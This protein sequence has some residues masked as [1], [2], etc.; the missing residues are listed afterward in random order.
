MEQVL[1]KAITT[2]TETGLYHTALLEWNGFDPADQTWPELKTH[3]TE[4]YD[5]LQ[6]SG[7]DTSATHGYHQGNWV[8]EEA[9]DDSIGS[10]RSSLTTIYQAHN[11]NT[12]AINDNLSAITTE[13]AQQRRSIEALQQ[14]IALLTINPPPAP[15]PVPCSA[16]PAYHAP[17][18]APTYTA[19]PAA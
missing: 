9:D 3:F 5:L 7:A 4:A 10:I 1:D 14:Q 17:P 12:V 19:P 6:Q 2:I 11:A 13:S 16:V 15:T 8:Q 18:P